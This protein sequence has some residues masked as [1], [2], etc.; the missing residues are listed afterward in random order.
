[1]GRSEASA[2]P[3]L[4]H[5]RVLQAVERLQSVSRASEDLNISQ[6][7]V[8][9][10]VAK[11]EA[12]F[13][14]PLFERGAQGTFTTPVG[15]QFLQRVCR[16]FDLL[17]LALAEVCDAAPGGGRRGV[18][19]MITTTHIR[20]LIATVDPATVAEVAREIGVSETSLYRSARDLE[21]ILRRAL[22]IR[23]PAGPICNA[24]GRQ[25][26]LQFRRAVREIDY[27]RE[28]VDL[29][30][31]ASDPQIVVGVLP[32]SGSVE[33]AGTIEALLKCRPSAR[34][35]VLAGTYQQMLDSL[36]EC[37]IDLLF[38]ILRRPDWV[39]DVEEE[40]LFQDSFSV[41]TRPGHPLARL[42][43]VTCED[44]SRFDWIAA[45]AGTP[46]R[47]QI[48]DLFRNVAVKPRL[49]IETS[50]L[51]TLRALLAQTDLITVMTR[52]E[53][54][55]DLDNGLLTCIDV[56]LH[57]S[58]PPKG[59]TTRSG[60]MPTEVHRKFLELLRQHTA[61]AAHTVGPDLR[62]TGVAAC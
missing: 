33:L 31:G 57:A 60:W 23:S 53:V 38:G 16:F 18:E 27:G 40:A 62:R 51:P 12:D 58:L 6:P 35:K 29:A 28:E 41:V 47:Q 11:M 10:A 43:R 3:N 2:L 21:H 48:D 55:F 24:A 32:M 54:S 9:Q 44:L 42:A 59:V 15:R 56:P 5:L 46:R 19:R 4:R 36:R 22:F 49:G 25:L 1:M 7:A 8:T 50:S 17:D 34:I 13:G 52:S 14:V 20:S 26:A 37:R 45:A 30:R 61:H 39:T